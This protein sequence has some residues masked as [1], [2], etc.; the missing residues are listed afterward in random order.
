MK[1]LYL[2]FQQ[3]SLSTIFWQ[4]WRSQMMDQPQRRFFVTTARAKML[5]RT[6]VTNVEYF[7]VSIVRNFTK[8]PGQQDSTE[9]IPW[10]N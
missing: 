1:I 10:K 4:Q 5:F 9:Y 8:N 3:I 2:L 7:Y 6:D